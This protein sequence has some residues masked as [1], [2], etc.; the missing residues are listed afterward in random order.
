MSGRQA[1]LASSCCQG[2][3]QQQMCA[4]PDVP[5][6][7]TS[8]NNVIEVDHSSDAEQEDDAGWYLQ[9]VAI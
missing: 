4:Q 7:P 3:Q 6:N 2:S 1:T 8:T 5:E 9:Y